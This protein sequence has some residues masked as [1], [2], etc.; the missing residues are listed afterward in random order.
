[1]LEL[2]KKNKGWIKLIGSKLLEYAGLALLVWGY[3]LPKNAELMD[4]RALKAIDTYNKIHN[5]SSKSFR[6][7][8]S[9]GT[10]IP[11]GRVGYTFVDWFN[12][13]KEFKANIDSLTPLIKNELSNI[14]PRLIIRNNREW[15]LHRDGEQ[16]RV[17]RDLE[18]FGWFYDDDG[19]V[20][21][22]YK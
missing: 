9:E 13:E 14:S 11:V 6:Q 22:I 10:D 2:V 5:K 17:R 15:W 7:I 12:D 1:M 3:W 16:Y 8:F 21:Y 18:G 20:Q 19:H 4:E